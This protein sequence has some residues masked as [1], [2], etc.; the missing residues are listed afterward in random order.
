LKVVADT[1]EFPHGE[2]TEK[3]MPAP[4]DSS[5][6]VNARD[7]TAPARTAAHETPGTDGSTTSACVACRIAC[8]IKS[9]QQPRLAAQKM[10]KWNEGSQSETDEL[11][12]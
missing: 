4:K 6:S 9:S 1:P 2:T 5:T 11:R 8:S 3:P 10:L 7:A 12:R